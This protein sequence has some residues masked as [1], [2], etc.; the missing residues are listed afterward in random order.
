[1]GVF[2]IYDILHR[3]PYAKIFYSDSGVL[4]R[5]HFLENLG[6]DWSASLLFFNG[7]E[8]F[9]YFFFFVYFI[10]A[11]FFLVG[12]KTRVTSFAL[13]IFTLSI[14]DR[15]WDVLNAGDD[16]IRMYFL[17]ACFLPFGARY[18]VDNALRVKNNSKQIYS[19]IWVFS[20]YFQIGLIYFITFLFKTGKQWRIDYTATEYAL[21]LN[22]FASFFGA[23]LRDFPGFL[24]LLT[25][26]SI[27]GELICPILLML[28]FVFLK[29][30][31]ISKLSAI[32]FGISFHI[33]LIFLMSLG[34]FPFF[35]VACWVAFIPS[36]IWMRLDS[37]RKSYNEITLFYDQDCKFCF[38]MV[39]IVKEFFLL[40]EVQ[41]EKAQNDSKVTSIMKSENSWVLRKN[42]KLFTKEN[43]FKQLLDNSILPPWFNQV[44][45]FLF[46][47]PISKFI[48]W[49]ISHNRGYASNVSSFLTPTK[50]FRKDGPFAIT[51]GALLILS[52]FYWN[53]KFFYPSV[54]K[55]LNFFK[56]TTRIFHSY[57]KWSMFSP[58]P[59]SHN[60]WYSMPAEFSDGTK[61]EIFDYGYIGGEEKP[62]YKELVWMNSLIK[63]YLSNIGKEKK[64]DRLEQFAKYN[65][66][67]FNAHKRELYSF[68]IIKYRQRVTLAS[69]KPAT[70]SKKI[71]WDHKCYNK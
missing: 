32:F 67:K 50:E 57:Q 52:L 49:K 44:L 55:N 5:G 7:T 33:G 4:P 61:K 26:F 1:M 54:K 36:E 42:N 20:Y 53:F 66:R 10:L 45:S 14:H 71:V 58:F 40:R 47:T 60:Q 65:C 2:L 51:L 64:K 69:D 29:K 68:K 27:Y 16:I 56:H 48:Y 12:F 23:F 11:T 63:K 9:T 37:K 28:G 24:K 70:I 34:G 18:S 43:V 59:Y 8:Y 21:G 15:N 30:G 19:S 62:S 3:I 13:W 17:I 46:S 38:K 39:R 25:M 22:N 31:Y 6:H 35:C 41:I